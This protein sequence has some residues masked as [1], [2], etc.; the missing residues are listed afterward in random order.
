MLD[1]RKVKKPK[2]SHRVLE[3]LLQIDDDLFKDL[4][5][6]AALVFPEAPEFALHTR[7]EIVV[8]FE[9]F[10]IAKRLFHDRS[11]QSNVHERWSVLANERFPI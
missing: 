11:P 4:F 9:E 6:V 7:N 8:V 2:R 1:L 5:Q 3:F 10:N